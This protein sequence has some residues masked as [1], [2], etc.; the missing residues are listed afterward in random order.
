[1]AAL[2]LAALAPAE[3]GARSSTSAGGPAARAAGTSLEIV[4]PRA[5]RPVQAHRVLMEAVVTLDVR[6]RAPARSFVTVASVCVR[7]PCTATVI[8]DERGRWRVPMR[9][10]IPNK[11]RS[12]V[13]TARSG[14]TSARVSVPI[15]LPPP[16]T[17]PPEKA[18]YFAMIGDSLAGGTAAWFPAMLPAWQVSSD[19]RS[20]RPLSEGM[21]VF[22]EVR[23]PERPRV[24]AFSLFTNDDPRTVGHLERQVR[25]SVARVGPGGCAVWATIARP[26]V[27]GV[28]YGEANDLL[29][30]LDIELGARLEV[31]HWAEAVAKNRDWVGR[32]EVH[33]TAKGYARRAA[34]YA[35]AAKRC[36]S[37]RVRATKRA[38]KH[39]RR[40][41]RAN[42]SKRR[43]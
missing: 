32:D 18:P 3:A 37:A 16:A 7:R 2:A 40:A 35:D 29:K 34:M 19:F 24:I 27:R 33:A 4:N 25:A 28:G 11:I 22:D 31:V 13:V 41:S 17:A 5:G 10:V 8:A 30:R 38:A 42:R 14:A 21:A 15:E 39:R 1:V 26:R 12:I 9:I 23:L 43:G 36:L 20:G 6:G